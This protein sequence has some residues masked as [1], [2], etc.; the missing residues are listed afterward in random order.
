MCQKMMKYIA[1]C[2]GLVVLNVSMAV[3]QDITA[4]NFNAEPIGKVIPDGTVINFKNEIIGQLTADSFVLNSK[5]DIIG[6]VVAQGFA[7][8]NDHKYLGKVLGDGTVRLP[9]GNIAGKIL[10]SGL[11]VD[12]TF[13]VVGSVL[14][15]GIVY[16]DSGKAVG[17][18]AGNGSYVDLAG[19]NIGFVSPSGYAYRRAE[20]SV[21]LEGRLLAA[22]MVVDLAG[23]FIGSVAPGGQVSNFEGEIIGRVHAN[24]YVYDN[25]SKIIGRVVKGGYAF[26]NQG[27]YLGLVSYNGE[28]VSKSK[29]VGKLR[30]DGLV[31]NLKGEVIGF[32]LPLSSVALDDKGQYLGYLVPEGKVVRGTSELGVVGPRGIV[33]DK[34]GKTIGFIAAA[35]PVFDH[36]GRLK[37]EAVTSGYVVSFEGAKLGFM[38]NDVAFNEAGVMMGGVLKPAFVLN[39]KQ[40]NLGLTG[41]GSD[42]VHG[43]QTYKVSPMGYVYNVDGVVSGQTISL[44]PSYSEN[45]ELYAYTE[46]NIQNNQ[47]LK[48]E[49]S[50]LVIDEQNEIKARQINPAFAFLF[51]GGE[52]DVLSQ[53]NI[54]YD[55]KENP[56]AKIVPEYDVVAFEDKKNDV[57][58]TAS[59]E[60][61]VALSVKGEMLGY[62]NSSGDVLS[63]GAYI[64]KMGKGQLI[65]N[66]NRAFLGQ[67]VGFGAVVNA[68]CEPLGVVGLKGEVRNGRDNVL[69]K[70]L[71]NRQAIS[72]VGQNIGHIAW[73]GPV[74]DTNG[75]FIG[76][77]NEIG[78]VLN[79]QKG[80]EGCLNQNGRVYDENGALKAGLVQLYPVM[81]FE[82][83][84]LGRVNLKNRLISPQNKDAGYALPDGTVMSDDEK[85]LGLAFKY[86]FAFDRD[87][88]FLGYVMASGEV[89]DDKNTVVGN[90]S[91]DGTLFFKNKIIGYALYD[92]YVY[93][94]N[95]KAIGYLTKNGTV[96]SFSGSKLG[97]AD[98]GFLLSKDGQLIGRGY[99]DY[100]V[101]D[102]QNNAVGE[103]M[104]SGEVVGL[105]GEVLGTISNSGEL[106][107]ESGKLLGQAKPLQYY[108]RSSRKS[109]GWAGVPEDERLGIQVEPVV[110]PEAK[111]KLP[112][113][114][115]KVIG[116]VVSPN[117]DYLGDLL[118]TGDVVDPKTGRIIGRSEDG[119]AIDENGDVLGTI[120]PID[121]QDGT[122]VGVIEGR[123]KSAVAP[124]PIFLP[125]DA[126]GTSKVPSNLGPG[127]GFGPG[128]RYDPVRARLLSEAQNV[129]QQEV[130]VGRISS[131]VNPSSITGW[132]DNWDNADYKLS[133][134]RVDMS[135]MILAD[136][137]IPA[138]LARTIMDSGG[139]SNVPVTAI[140]ERNVYA[141]DGRNVVIPAGSRVMGYSSGGGSSSSG[142]AVRVD[143]TWTRLIRPDG[144]AF[145]FSSAQ[146]GDA[147]G[148]GGALG[149][150]DEQLLQRYTAP[151]ATS[152]M[153]S[154]LVYMTASGQTTTS[155][156]G[157][158]V[159]DSKAAASNQA[160]Q[161]FLDQMD[162]IFNDLIQ[163]KMAIN[164][165]TYVP[166]GTRLIIFPKVDLWLR[167]AQREKAHLKE[168]IK[169][170]EVLIDDTDPIGSLQRGRTSNASD[171]VSGGSQV[172][173][174]GK[175]DRI[176]PSQPLIDDRAYT[177]QRRARAPGAVP[178]PPSSTSSGASSSASSSSTSSSADPSTGQLF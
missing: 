47:T 48:I 161:N 71:L 3:A 106:R 125:P 2:L 77:A 130:K 129:R 148:R 175:D 55:G 65:L 12:D 177:K 52:G 176:E 8:G 157:N 95:G 39:T 113:Y 56:I 70:V 107:D 37:A 72:E 14:S 146:T 142:S 40:E 154:A 42:F 78:Q 139:A 86:K 118:E 75:R 89:L 58:G 145:E 22:K 137:P 69:G 87:N 126:Y 114:S 59:N 43:A 90:V 74:Y 158:T 61:G 135:E 109:A 13:E 153:S 138:V 110:V 64:G 60:R 7:V 91:N 117:G 25:G 81:S 83:K 178:P 119:L 30:A 165:V 169:K 174:S 150:L 80:I 11:V 54:F 143:I 166:A 66:A 96:M 31:S 108:V 136:K 79:A 170:P 84:I 173:Y 68:N 73:L 132:Q 164:S 152:L 149:Y 112:S 85:V 122:R 62:V 1:I 63:V 76:T 102:K 17:R 144:V 116:V 162:Y 168:S 97:K 24:G 36:L 133:S 53:T 140:V 128:E 124:S 15:S 6:G 92:L 147:Q 111:E 151:I 98:R 34:K 4:I 29:I 67:N 104:L 160:R 51:D 100:F 23:Q 159:Q 50:G 123:R 35:G 57:I 16:N 120:E 105:G 127:G 82:N 163:R 94:E 141:E 156:D 155:S 38:K 32:S 115:E 20:G 41:I 33:V 172:V 134:W 99:R 44:A 10:P 5:G 103:L 19:N 26:D 93:D 121:E 46:L 49:N 167:T 27:A 88:N 101:R 45:G 9:S 18:V 21:V 171:S 131:S 28:I